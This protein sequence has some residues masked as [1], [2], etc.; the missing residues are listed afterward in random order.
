MHRAGTINLIHKR[1]P[2]IQANL[3]RRPHSLAIDCLRLLQMHLAILTTLCGVANAA[4][5]RA[6]IDNLNSLPSQLPDSVPSSSLPGQFD[7]IDVYISTSTSTLSSDD[8]QAQSARNLNEPRGSSDGDV[9]A[10]QFYMCCQQS[11]TTATIDHY[12]PPY[13]CIFGPSTGLCPKAD[14]S[15]PY[16]WRCTLPGL[17][18]GSFVSIYCT[19]T[20]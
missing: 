12:Y 13:A 7:G 16:T 19:N 2:T 3:G 1:T 14:S 8:L 4:F 9:N 18:A 20:S 11:D 15:F 10:I 5:S 17:W 6:P